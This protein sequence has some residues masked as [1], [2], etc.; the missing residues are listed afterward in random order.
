MFPHLKSVFHYIT[1]FVLFFVTLLFTLKCIVHYTGHTNSVT[2]FYNDLIAYCTQ[3]PSHLL[4]ILDPHILFPESLHLENNV[5][6][7]KQ[8][9][10]SFLEQFHTRS[11]NESSPTT[12]GKSFADDGWR[13]VILKFYNK[14]Y[15]DVQKH[16]PETMRLLRNCGHKV[17]LAM[18]SV[19]KAHSEIKYHTGPF[20]GSMRY[21]LGLKVPQDR[22]NCFI[23]VDKYK[24]SWKEG[25]SL[26]FD[27]TY[28]HRVVNDT[29]EDRIVLFLDIQRTGKHLLSPVMDWINHQVC[30]SFIIHSLSELNKENEKTQKIKN[31]YK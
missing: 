23:Q 26:L 31:M 7:I 8:E 15:L 30:N 27:D 2:T 25:E 13:I 22:V 12:F 28:V 4:P 16:F 24:Y 5:S 3:H 29:D 11:A 6:L 9:I 17:K 1:C 21:H 10:Q 19:L 18:F 14:E 20:R